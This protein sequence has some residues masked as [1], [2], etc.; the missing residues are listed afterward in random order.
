M[1]GVYH[2]TK[3]KFDQLMN[4]LLANRK[5]RDFAQSKINEWRAAATRQR[6][7][8][9]ELV[10]ALTKRGVEWKPG[11]FLENLLSG[12]QNREALDA[13]LEVIDKIK[14][15]QLLR[16]L[17]SALF[18]YKMSFDAEK[19]ITVFYNIPDIML[20]EEICR[21]LPQTKAYNTDQWARNVMS[22]PLYTVGCRANLISFSAGLHN[23]DGLA[24]L[25][26]SLFD[27]FPMYVPHPLGALAEERHV[28]FMRDRLANLEQFPETIRG[29]IRTNLS[30]A[31]AKAEK[32]LIHEA[33]R[34]EKL[35]QKEAEKQHLK[36]ERVKVKRD[37]P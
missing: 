23:K 14:D 30:N 5:S 3:D 10:E 33:A 9:Q 26:M 1:F 11:V 4:D 2:M 25:L 29:Y 34:T 27:E 18:H 24:D 37:R 15:P 32:R 6:T 21:I 31:I 28:D 17:I 20:Q 36:E 8:L 16:G 7:N 35:A 22:M 19:V 13:I 12:P